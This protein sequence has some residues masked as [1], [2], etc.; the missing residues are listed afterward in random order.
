MINVIARTYRLLMI[1]LSKPINS[2]VEQ[3]YIR[4][5]TRSAYIPL[6]ANKV[7]A[8][9]PSP[10]ADHIEARLS[11]DDYLV[12]NPTATYF[13]RVKGDSM[14]NAGI[15][16]NDVLVVDRS[17]EPS[18]GDI[19]LAEVDGEFT[20]KYLSNNQLLP[21]NPEYKPISFS[22]VDSVVLIGVVTGSM[23]KF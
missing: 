13:V 12:K 7:A 22:D 5:S 15:F 2:N 8:G 11:A 19:I 6:F 18:I 23:R 20:V 14:I 16:D 3:I 1:S 4:T 21:A 10:A 17:L 9:F